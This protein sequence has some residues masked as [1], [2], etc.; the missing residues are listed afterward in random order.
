MKYKLLPFK[1]KLIVFIS[2]FLIQCICVNAQN[3]NLSISKVSLSK[4]LESI[5]K[6]TGYTFAY[7]GEINADSLI[8]EHLSVT[9][10]SPIP[11]FN[12]F[13]KQYGI[14]YKLKDKYVIL[15]K[16]GGKVD[17]SNTQESKK[18][19]IDGVITDEG[20]ETLP[21]ASVKNLST[22]ELSCTDAFGRFAIEAKEGDKILFNSIG[23]TQ[24]SIVASKTLSYNVIL[25]T[26]VI[27]LDN[28]VVTGYQTLSKERATGSFSVITEKE[29]DL[30]VSSNLIDKLDGLSPG[31]SVDKNNKITIRGTGT[32]YGD[33]QPLLVVDGF[34]ISGDISTIN[35][36]DVA[37]I[38]VLKD[39]SAASV[40]GTKAANGVIVV[41]TKQ[42]RSGKGVQVEASYYCTVG[43]KPKVSD[44]Q[45]QNSSDRIDM[46]LD[47]YG[48]DYAEG[49]ITKLDYVSGPLSESYS[50]NE[51]QQAWARLKSNN[52]PD[53]LKYNQTQFNEQINKLKS[54]DGFKQYSDK[55]LRNSITN[56]FNISVRH[57][58]EVNSFVASFAYDNQQSYSLGDA[59]DRIVVN[60][61]DQLK[62]AKNLELE[63][64]ANLAYQSNKENGLGI[65]YFSKGGNN[66]Y[67][68]II[69][70]NGERAYKY[71]GNFFYKQEHQKMGLNY[72]YNPIDQVEN[73]N[74]QIK[75]LSA[76][77]QAGL[78][79]K[80][81]DDFSISTKFQ[82]EREYS[83]RENL[84]SETNPMWRSTLNAY[85]IND[86][87]EGL[88]YGGFM[89]KRTGSVSSFIWR[90]QA[91]YS[92]SFNSNKHLINV[93]G[94]FEVR[95][96][97][98]E[99]NS[100]NMLGYNSKTAS[101]TSYDILGIIKKT[102]LSRYGKEVFTEDMTES[103]SLFPTVSSADLRERSYYFN[104]SYMLLDKY[105]FTA[106]YRLDQASLFGFNK[107]ARN[108]HLWS[109]GLSWNLSKEGFIKA[110]FLDRLIL[111]ATY[112]VN[113]NRPSPQHTAFLSGLSK[114]S[115]GL[116]SPAG[117]NYINL[118]NPPNP[119]L[120]SEK[121]YTTNIGV[122]YSFFN[123]RIR[124]SLELYNKESKDL[125]GPQSLDPTSGWSAYMTNYASV[126]NKGIEFNVGATPV[127]AKS[128]VWDINFNFTYNVN[129]V[130]NIDVKPIL[131]TNYLHQVA[132][133]YSSYDGVPIVGKPID[134]LYAYKWGGLSQDGLPRIKDANGETITYS[135]VQF[136]E[137]NFFYQGTTVAPYFGSLYNNFT[138]KNLSIG[139]NI[140]Y[141]FGHK[142]R[143]PVG[144]QIEHA[145][146]NDK[147]IHKSYS[148]YW[149]KPGDEAH[150]NVPRFDAYSNYMMPY[151]FP[152]YT[153]AD[154]NV[155]DAS[156]AK[157]KDI[158]IDYSFPK[159]WVNKIGLASLDIRL[160][161]KNMLTVVAN[162]WGVDPESVERSMEYGLESTRLGFTEPKTVILGIKL[163]F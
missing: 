17:S 154:I 134:R 83:N 98:S 82:Y 136:N 88:P 89:Q 11:F 44:L 61:R 10:K 124:G 147:M 160:Q 9:D 138:F 137:G 140:I 55:L 122:D 129:K 127:R 78:S 68:A 153:M 128:F 158:N 151:Y 163:S 67:D 12:I 4:V 155:L 20:G 69:T 159:R 100:F 25:K 37:S 131:Y 120:R 115:N 92:K 133:T 54:I 103:G 90:S 28:I 152:F 3:I 117:T 42:G 86:K 85:F 32:L 77:L 121:V 71:I 96:T 145:L 7:S 62:V 26:D 60:L 80:I 105:A 142:M 24:A 35:P 73:N 107:S 58:T 14:S 41:T 53:N 125:V 87:Y 34:P 13:F 157:L 116:T 22:G 109:T 150:T 141:R 59:N 113:G 8:V 18:R 5:T 1:L 2:C 57:N 56:K 123:S 132:G 114:I 45:L 63:L 47:Y 66:P 156:Y 149:K 15:F 49:W 119:N 40:W 31:L 94:G 50:F 104:A 148:N 97:V 99:Y 39:A 101:G 130:K 106:S 33:A 6:Q 43:F 79:Y 72:N 139:F 93:I 126:N 91:N 84:Q 102:T 29:L 76:R 95:K 23:M 70:A 143:A 64:S 81:N 118:I 135:D 21:G 16:T 108:N 75:G 19:I 161:L 112:G 36:E 51:L 146:M 110:D 30:R 27:A 144:D 52:I 65:S 111:R 74:V 38:T 46:I 162:D 48:K